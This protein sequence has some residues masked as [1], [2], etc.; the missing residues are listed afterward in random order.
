MHVTSGT[1]H[2]GQILS[3][4]QSGDDTGFNLLCSSL[5]GLRWL[6]ARHV[7]IA[8]AEDL[9]QQ[10]L[11]DLIK[12]IRMGTPFAPDKFPAYVHSMI[13][14]NI[15]TFLQ[16]RCR[17]RRREC[18][19]DRVEADATLNPEEQAIRA[20]QVKIM[21]RILAQMPPQHRDVL[22]RFY[23]HGQS[24]ESIQQDLGLGPVEFRNVKCRAKQRFEEL[25]RNRL[26]SR[27]STPKPV[28]V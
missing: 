13:R 4:I 12:Q 25:C 21:K 7:G 6:I 11:T 16:E 26:G 17:S 22:I 27:P 2:W 24:A 15:A 1:P 3:Q 9:Y 23:F 14:N 20:E 19:T 5:P 18:G 8:D 28:Q 10:T